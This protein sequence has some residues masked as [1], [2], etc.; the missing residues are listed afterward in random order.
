VPR[1]LLA[2]LLLV[3]ASMLACED[4]AEP[5]RWALGLK[6]DETVGTFLNAWGSERGEV[7]AVGGNPDR[8]AMWR[9]DGAIWTAE[10]VPED[11]PL[12]NWVSGLDTDAGASLWFA[13]NAGQL[14]LREPSGGWTR[15]ALTSSSALW[16][17]FAGADDD[18]WAVGGDIPG[19][20]PVLAHWDGAGWT[21][22]APP[23]A[24]RKYDALLK[25]WGHASDRVW[26][27]GHRGVVFRF[28]GSAWTQQL[29]GT[30]SDLISLWGTPE[31]GLVAVGGRA[32]GVIARYDASADAWTSQTIG[33]LPGLNGV[34]VDATGEAFAVGIDGV[35]IAIEPGGFEWRELDRSARPD[36][37]HGAFGL[38]DGARFGVGGNLLYSPPWT[39]VIVQLLP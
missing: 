29:A 37:L 36:T 34:W 12:I 15:M 20:A 28:D 3:F 22:L 25:V 26:A 17:I 31:G 24:D 18:V 32:N 9:F 5:A 13:G 35:V 10:S 7:Y 14:A 6:V 23:P 2:V 19:D 1:S 39:G 16:G 4:G 38:P 33:E 27:V 21:E 8:G 30:T 11:M